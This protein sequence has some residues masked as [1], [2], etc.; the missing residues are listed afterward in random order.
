MLIIEEQD[1]L[2]PSLGVDFLLISNNAASLSSMQGKINFDQL[3]VDS[4]NS[5]Y[6]A[7]KLVKEA[8]EAQ[9]PLHSVHHQGYFRIRL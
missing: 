5:F 7:D 8:A 1:A 4:S 3:I 2:I 6:F 9:V